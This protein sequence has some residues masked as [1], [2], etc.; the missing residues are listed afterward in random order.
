MST[1][2]VPMPKKPNPSYLNDYRPVALASVIIFECLVCNHLSSVVLEP[3]QFAYR[4][5]RSVEDAVS[6]FLHSIF[7]HLEAFDTYAR[8]L[9]V[10]YSSAFNT[11][12]PSR[13]YDKLSH[14]GDPY[15]PCATACAVN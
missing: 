2:I 7:Q 6:L 9:F 5:N 10:D 15:S 1:V 13:L 4:A 14:M 11:I 8:V 12:L 3:Y